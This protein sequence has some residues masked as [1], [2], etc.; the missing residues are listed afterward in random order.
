[1]KSGS[2]KIDIDMYSTH[3][4]VKSAF[5]ERFTRTLKN[6][7][8]KHMTSI[9]KHA[10]IDKLSDIENEYNNTY[11]RTI[12]MKFVDVKDNTYIEFCNEVHDWDSKFKVGDHVIMLEYQNT[13][14]LLLK[15]IFQISLKRFLWLKMLKIFL[16]GHILLVI[17]MVK[18]KVIGTFYEKILQKTNKKEFRIEK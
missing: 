1:M 8:Y 18:K 5:T 7:I 17:W 13:N 2:K 6:E 3:N 4:E 9:S 14:I 15:D 10:Y 16:H 11:N 12:K